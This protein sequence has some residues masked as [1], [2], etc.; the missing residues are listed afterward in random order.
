M[1]QLNY[2]NIECETHFVSGASSYMVRHQSAIVKEFIKK[3]V[4]VSPTLIAGAISPHFHHES[5]KS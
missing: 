5:Y 3:K 1:H 2:S 4:F